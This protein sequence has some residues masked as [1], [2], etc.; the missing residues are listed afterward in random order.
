MKSIRRSGAYY[1][2]FK[3]GW[4]DPLDTSYSK[5]FGARWNA[6]GSFGALYLNKT[7]EVAA[8]NAR[9]QHAGRAIGLFDLLPSRR[10]SL[11][12]VNVP[13]STLLDAVTEE[14][15]A[16]LG[17]PASYPFGVPHARCQPI[18]KRAYDSGEFRGIA[19]RSAA[20]ST[21]T[22]WVGEELAWFDSAP[23][24]QESTSRRAFKDWYPH[25]FPR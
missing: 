23:P 9:K 4:S 13:R 21:A 2:V 12:E 8:A 11:L 10:P 18:G 24:L 7:L 3:P 19:Y 1:R 15:I 5:R 6:P 17:L 22:Y 14:G 20:E 25:P 16:D